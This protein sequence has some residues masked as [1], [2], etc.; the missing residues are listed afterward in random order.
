VHVVPTQGGQLGSACAGDRADP[1]GQ[2]CR[3][4]ELGRRRDHGTNVISGHRLA[5]VRSGRPQAC[6]RS[7][8]RVDPP[9]SLCLRERGAQGAMQILDPGVLLARSTQ[10]GVPPFDIRDRQPGDGQ[11][12]D[13]Q[14]SQRVVGLDRLDPAALVARR[15]RSPRGAVVFDPLVERVA[16]RPAGAR[17]ATRA[18]LEFDG[19]SVGVTL[20]TADGPRRLRGPTAVVTTSEDAHLPDPWLLLPDRRHARIAVGME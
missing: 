10:S 18:T 3:R 2:T 7:D 15:R 5:L 20:A 1:Q 11:P 19:H 16:D 17:R 6:E 9:P 12:G 13:G 4:V 8:I 14:P